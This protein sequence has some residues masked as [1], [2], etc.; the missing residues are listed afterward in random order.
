MISYKL[1]V[2]LGLVIS[3]VSEP[4]LLA[5]TDAGNVRFAMRTDSSFDTYT[6]SPSSSTK[7]WLDQHFWRMQTTTPYFDSGL[8]WFPNAWA[9]EDLY[10]VHTSDSLV[11]QHPDWILKD[12]QGNRMYIPYACSNGACTQYAFDPGNSGFVNWWISNA[13]AVLGKGYV[14]L[15]IDDV[16]MEF[17]VGN[18]SGTQVAPV[19]PRTGTTMTYTAWKQYIASFVTQIRTKVKVVYPN[20]TLVHNSIWYAGGTARDSDPS[21]ISQIEA[22]D[23]INNER[24][25]SD[26]GLTSGTGVWSVN[27][28]LAYVDRVHSRGKYV[29]MDEYTFNGDYG[30]AGYFLVSTGEDA[31]GNHLVT[32][33]N[34]FSGYNAQLGSPSAARYTW[35]NLLRRD[36]SNGM[37]LLNLPQS[38]TVTVNL[39]ATYTNTAGQKV[40][41]VTLAA[42]QA[43]VLQGTVPPE[44]TVCIDAG[45]LAEGNF[46][47]DAD[48]S[49]GHGNTITHVVTT[50]GVANAAPAAVY[51]SKRTSS[52]TS[53]FTYT[54][55]LLEPG[56]QYTVRLHFADDNSSYVGQR[57]FNVSI[58]GTQVMK[59]FDVF[60]TAGKV[61]YKA[62][63]EQFTAKA[64]ANGEIVVS[65]TP[66]ASGNALL[67]GLEIIP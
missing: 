54:V 15:W 25:I 13:E 34:W 43:A 36:F 7:Q 62:V 35:N 39:P 64:T 59:N 8:S 48:Y 38:A 52:G 23:Y 17:R 41:K 1:L 49:G 30:I 10:G 45:G 28:F 56:Q 16:N 18:G 42:G 61:A 24:G 65:F 37:V 2:C 33:N 12:A 51:Q 6:T 20:A 53:G 47:A 9:Y 29:I 58:N 66:G 63:V 46:M 14:G 32:P 55:P 21:V 50:S 60:S 5:Q 22:A 67:S 31:F 57:Q 44:N 19:D 4:S 3:G 27:A 40:S 11:N 26:P